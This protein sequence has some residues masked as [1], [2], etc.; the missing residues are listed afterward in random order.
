MSALAAEEGGT[1]E[2]EDLESFRLRAR[3][4]IRAN[5]KPMTMEELRLDYSRNDEEAELAEI[6]HE[7]EL[8]R[9]CSTPGWL[10]SAS[11]EAYGGQGLTPA[12]QKVFNEEI[13]GHEYPGRIQ[14]PDVLAL[15]SRHPGVRDRG[16]EAASHPGHPARRRAV[17]AV[18][19]RAERRVRRGRGA[20]PPRCATASSG[21]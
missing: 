11:R 14:V 13:V 18:P 21:W 3:G 7:R 16:A 12:H 19:V 10:G 1:E 6:A 15:R 8:Q 9:R 2:M 5:L 20:R 4:F 17:D